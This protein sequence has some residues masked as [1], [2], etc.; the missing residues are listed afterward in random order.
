MKIHFLGAPDASFARSSEH[1]FIPYGPEIPPFAVDALVVF[2]E[3]ETEDDHVK[4]LR[5]SGRPV[6]N[7]AFNEPSSAPAPAPQKDVELNEWLERLG[8]MP[9]TN[10]QPIDCNFYDKNRFV[11]HHTTL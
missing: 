8:E 2:T 3:V 5:R 9:R 10:Y 1:E 6:L 4:T 11:Q 7:L